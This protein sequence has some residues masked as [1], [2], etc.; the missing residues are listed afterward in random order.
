MKVAI[1]GGTGLLGRYLIRCL[2][3]HGK[4]KP[5]IISRKDIKDY[6]STETRITDYSVPSLMNIISDI[7]AVVHL[8]AQ[9]G[10]SN[11][12]RDFDENTY[13]TQ[14]LFNTC[15]KIGISNVVYAST[16]AVYSKDNKLPWSEKDPPS[17]QTMYGISKLCSEHIGS[18]Y[19]REYGLK[20]KSLRFPPIFG[21]IDIG[22][23]M[24][25]RMVNRFMLL[26]LEKQTLVLYSQSTGIRE[27]LYA[28]DAAQAILSALESYELHGAF[29]IGSGEAFTNHEVAQYI[30]KAFNND[31]NLIIKNLEE[32]P[33]E[34]SFMT[35]EK[36]FNQLGFKSKYSFYEAMKDIYKE[37]HDV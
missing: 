35:S 15:N 33:L 9:R 16:I 8:A 32:R 25:E 3:E 26:A 14:N 11:N 23:K 28:K 29:N 4:H 34:S 27:F 13:I 5:I 12:L 10:S 7:D 20:V 30:N 21:V 18:Y 1:T 31:G 2:N 24:K 22:D 36:A 17:P 19:S 6:M 37:I